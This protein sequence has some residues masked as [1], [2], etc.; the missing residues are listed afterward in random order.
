MPRSA[1][2]SPGEI[3]DEISR[4]WSSGWQR[5]VFPSVWL[6]YLAQTVSGVHEHSSGVA[7]VVGYLIVVAFAVGYLAALPMGWQH[8]YR[9]FYT[10]Y[11]VCV[12][13]F[14]AECFFAEDDAMVFLVYLAV[15]TVAA[16]RWWSA[17]VILAMVFIATFGA[18]LVPAWDVSEPDWTSGLSVLLVAFAMTGFFQIIQSNRELAAARAEVAR[19]A[20]ENER[21]RIARDLHDLLGHSLTTITVKAGLARRLAQRGDAQRSLTEITEVEQLSRRTLGDV[22][23]A[24]AG[25]RDVTLA[26]ELATA[27]EVLRAAGIAAELPGSVDVVDAELSEL[28]GWVLRE[29]LT[30]VVRH[31]HAE[32]CRVT[33]GPRWIEIS[34]TGRGGVPGAGNGLVGLR[35]RVGTLGGTVTTT[36]GFTGFTLRAEVPP[37]AQAVTP[38]PERSEVEA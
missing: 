30:N 34:D 32:Q 5:Y 7:A 2:C 1:D 28:F 25:H 14:V 19:L 24:V 13:L 29:G 36:S 15:L 38:R 31:S 9:A 22:R 20:A 12:A 11:G 35:E 4:M 26:G 18:T 23:A 37:A 21:S 8:Q 16:R 6:V 17:W 27:R 3:H 10:V 33:L